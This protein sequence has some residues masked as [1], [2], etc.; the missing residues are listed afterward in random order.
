MERKD[1][2][3]YYSICG[4]IKNC[5]NCKEYEKEKD[6]ITKME[7]GNVTICEY[8]GKEKQGLSFMIGAAKT[9]DWCMIEGTGKI[10]CPDCYEKA[11]E[12]G[13]K[14]IKNLTLNK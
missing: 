4:S 10:A 12:E 13:Q 6:V 14:I 1:C 2:K 11:T 5:Q 7:D 3:S 8:C 9:P